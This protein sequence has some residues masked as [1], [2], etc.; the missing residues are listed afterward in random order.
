MGN[1]A[2]LVEALLASSP[3]ELK[4]HLNLELTGRFAAYLTQLVRG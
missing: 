1:V 2:L 3:S 4:D